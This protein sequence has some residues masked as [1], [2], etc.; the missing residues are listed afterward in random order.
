MTNATAI[1]TRTTITRHHTATLPSGVEVDLPLAPCEHIDPFLSDDGTLLRYAVQDEGGYDYEWQEGVE[2][3]QG[4]PHCLNYL[5]ADAAND[6]IAEM[7]V[8]H[9]VYVVDVYEHGNIL[10]SLSGNGP[11][12]AFDTAR[13]G[14]AIAI[15]NDKH[16]NPFTNTEEAAAA[17]LS[18]YTSWCNGDVYGVVEMTIDPETGEMVGGYDD[19]WGII[20]WEYAEECLKH[21][22]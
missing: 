7:S 13:G 14:A 20:G 17:I 2:F 1:R 22:V 15:P 4:N 16:D 18:E 21:G 6:W 5:D 11:Q 8:D 9:D 12:C 19:C 10:Y 3:V